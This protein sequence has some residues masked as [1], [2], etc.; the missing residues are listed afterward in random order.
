MT[1]LAFF[2]SLGDH[3][4]GRAQQAIVQRVPLLHLA[5]HRV[6]GMILGGLLHHGL[7]KVGIKGFSN[8]FDRYDIMT[9]QD[10]LHFAEGQT[11][12]LQQRVVVAAILLSGRDGPLH[13]VYHR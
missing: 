6:G 3:H 8:G 7:M 10:L 1:A 4:H 2:F 5:D 13:V 9:F 12:S 11:N